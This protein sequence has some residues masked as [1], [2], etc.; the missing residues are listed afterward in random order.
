MIILFLVAN[1]KK[2][3]ALQKQIVTLKTIKRVRNYWITKL[4]K[5]HIL[6]LI[7]ASYAFINMLKITNI[8]VLVRK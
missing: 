8:F 6:Y 5:F 4:Q 7:S 2:F 1:N 3:N